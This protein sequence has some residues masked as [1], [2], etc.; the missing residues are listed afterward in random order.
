MTSSQWAVW[1]FTA[2][3]YDRSN[4]VSFVMSLASLI[5]QSLVIVLATVVIATAPNRKA[6]LLAVCMGVN[7]VA[8]FIVKRVI[9][10]DRPLHPFEYA[11]R[12][13]FG[14]PSS[15]AQFMACISAAATVIYWRGQGWRRVVRCFIGVCLASLVGLSRVY[16]HYHTE[17]QVVAGL[18]LG[19]TLGVLL[20]SMSLLSDIAES[21]GVP[22]AVKIRKLFV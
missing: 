15:H 13:D 10:H 11:K 18:A 4:P 16:N 12:V 14:M 9:R 3:V 2:A 17:E 8:N 1:D 5:P 6:T 22:V 19:T 20:S 21:I 7:E